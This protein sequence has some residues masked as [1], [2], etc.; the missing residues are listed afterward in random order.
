MQEKEVELHITQHAQ[1]ATITRLLGWNMHQWG[2]CTARYDAKTFSVL[3]AHNKHPLDTVAKQMGC[4]SVA[5]ARALQ[6]AWR[7]DSIR[8]PREAPYD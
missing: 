5:E 7:R 1:S 3:K 8:D 6:C 4:G 2:V